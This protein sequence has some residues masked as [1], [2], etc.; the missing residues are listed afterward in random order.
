MSIAN[1]TLTDT[2]DEWRVKTNQLIAQYDETNTLAI[3]SFE[4]ANV[5][6]DIAAN[7]GA[8]IVVSNAV[9]VSTISDR[10]NSFILPTVNTIYDIANTANFRSANAESNATIAFYKSANAEVNA[11][12][13]LSNSL[14]AVLT[15]ANAESNATIALYKSANAESN[16]TIAFYKSAN[17]E[18]NIITFTANVSDQVAN[19]LAND[20]V[21]Q[22]SINTAAASVLESILANTDFGASFNQSNIAYL[23]ANASFEQANTARV[24]ANAS[25]AKANTA[26]ANASTTFAG[27]LIITGN[28]TLSGATAI[29]NLL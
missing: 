26:L 23:Q 3:A 5:S 24:H 15:S 1:V 16:A 13:A 4:Y 12:F 18:S 8:N 21:Y 6:I 29:L 2:F 7:V 19:I 11:T 27:D 9:F 20:P 17:A 25:F 28:L 22:N 10:A 14:L